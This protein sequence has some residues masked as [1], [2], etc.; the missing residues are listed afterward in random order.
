MNLKICQN[1][2][3]SLS[4]KI[5]KHYQNLKK[6]FQNHNNLQKTINKKINFNVIEEKLKSIIVGQ[7]EMIHQLIIGFKRPTIAGNSVKKVKNK[8]L[9]TGNLENEK[10]III[11]KLNELLYLES[12]VSSPKVFIFD[13]ALYPSLNEEKLFFQDLY[14]L[15][16][17]KNSIIV[18]THI[19]KCA[20]HYL[21]LIKELLIK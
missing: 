9:L 8:I 13:L 15:V 5:H 16:V 11:E 20:T 14:S 3:I 18:I 19:D 12:F 21:Q 1:K 4:K 7:D 6:K 2:W 10:T 17:Q